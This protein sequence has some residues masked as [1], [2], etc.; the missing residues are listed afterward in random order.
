M[1]SVQD[2]QVRDGN[3]YCIYLEGLRFSEML[4]LLRTIW[5]DLRSRDPPVHPAQV[6]RDFAM[7]FAELGK[8][9]LC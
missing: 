7:R 1:L 8:N 2:I 9:T 4:G 3:R 6:M 5:T